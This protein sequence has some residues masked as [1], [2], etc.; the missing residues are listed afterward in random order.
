MTVSDRFHPSRPA[1]LSVLLSLD[2]RFRLAPE[3]LDRLARAAGE[4]SPA[5]WEEAVEETC[6][7]WTA[8]LLCHH[9]RQ[10]GVEPPAK[11]QR[12]Y[13]RIAM[14]A[15]LDEAEL[16][17]LGEALRGAGVG[18]LLIKGAALKGLVYT[19][20]G[21]RP[22]DDSDWV[23]RTS[24]D[25]EA[26]CRILAGQGYASS[27]GGL[28]A[29]WERGRFVVE[30]HR[31]VLGD[32]RVAGRVSGGGKGGGDADEAVWARS[33]PAPAGG[34]FRMPA[35]EDHLLILCAHLMK[36]NLEPGI[37]FADLEGLLLAGPGLDWEAVLDRARAWGLL[38]PLAYALR[39]L[40]LLGEGTP[41]SPAL[42]LPPG[43]RAALTEVRPGALDRLLL[44]LAGQGARLRGEK[45]EWERPPIGNLL[46]LSSREGAG[47]KLR[48]LREAAFPRH[49]VMEQI[50]PGYHPALRGWFLLRRAADLLRL[51][52]RVAAQ[53]ALR[54]PG[55]R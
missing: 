17:R 11:L 28:G 3:E 8:G 18:V 36:H 4:A 10:A 29:A 13:R 55:G 25:W 34:P 7:R 22:A 20:P 12:E 44:S 15:V 43:V 49:E 14:E 42:A 45:E 26:A 51:A 21:L 27:E 6:F 23:I 5:E 32:E 54:R 2:A 48:L 16:R 9:L 1:P 19:N 24:G 39:G 31:N 37:W 33:L 47:S 50:Y 46:W 53:A 40:G 52:A 35:P 38:R 30:L 41:G